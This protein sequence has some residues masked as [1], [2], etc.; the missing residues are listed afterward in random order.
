MIKDLILK[1]HFIDFTD[2]WQIKEKDEAKVFEQFVNYVILS[3]DTV[4]TFIGHPEILDICCTGGGDDAKL[5]GIGIKINGQLIGSIEDIDEIVTANKKIDVEFFVI[6]AKERT[7]FESEAVNTF[8]VGVRNFFSEP[9][10]P[11]NEKVKE[12]RK[13]KDYILSKENVFR[14]LN[15]NPLLHIYYVFCG[16][17]P[18]DEHTKGIK[19]QFIRDMENCS[20][21]FG[22][23]TFDIIDGKQLVEKCKE[24]EN[25]FKVELYVRDIIPLTVNENALIKKA[26]AFTCE[27]MELLK[28]LSKEDGSLRRSLFN[29]NVRDYLG[30]RGGVNSEIENTIKSDPE[31]FLMCNNGITIVC[32]N[33]LQIK[34]KLVSIDNPQIVNGCQTCTTI[35][36]QR[37]AFSLKKVQVLVKLI[38]TEDSIITN[39]VVRGTNKQNQV[40]EESFETTK[41]FHQDLEDYFIAKTE[42]IQLFYERRNKQ[43]SA[44]P[45]I[46]RYQIVNLR[47]LTQSFVATFLQSPYMAH[48]HEAKLLQ[49]FIKTESQRKIYLQGHSFYAYYI[50]GLIWYKFEDA[51]RRKVLTKDDRTYQAHLY[52][53][54][55][56][57]T[58]MYPLTI[59]SSQNAM[60]KYCF[61]LEQL[62]TSDHFDDCLHKARAVFKQCEQKWISIG[63]SRYGMKDTKD[64]TDELTCICREIFVN[65]TQNIEKLPQ[66]IHEKWFYGKILSYINKDKWFAFIK[67]KDFENNVYFDNKSYNSEIRKLVPGQKCRFTIP[68]DIA[69]GEEAV[70]AT[71]VELI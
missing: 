24:L 11:E 25:D 17:T 19:K 42:P 16:K 47:V 37:D 10:F 34:D 22:N 60:E 49:E 51:F 31:M 64:F 59:D 54:I 56:F 46:N 40:L 66:Y 6:Q 32:T 26:Y 55:M 28:L 39:K 44:N 61:N 48:R 43:Y 13:F 8:G 65:K 36:L 9:M 57:M 68:L 21:Y 52:Y 18:D 4:D 20:T 50:S 5:D 38:C 15:T 30:N 29:N 7:K 63:K 3:Q 33:F 45:T 2:A 69:K 1:K 41:S 35:Y 14:K 53:I 62:L 71:K 70:C 58:G 27:A 67:C 12:L 23:I